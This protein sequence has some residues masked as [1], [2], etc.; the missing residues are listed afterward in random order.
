[1]KCSQIR[2]ILDFATDGELGL[3]TTLRVK[4]HLARCAACR[5]E[6][7]QV[8]AARR[9]LASAATAEPPPTLRET[10]L[11]AAR[12][13]PSHRPIPRPG[14][15]P[16]RAMAAA[17]AVL[18]VVA[19][20]MAAGIWSITRPHQIA[21]TPPAPGPAVVAPTSPAAAPQVPAAPQ[22]ADKGVQI[23]SLPAGHRA[24][25]SA[26]GI[27][28]RPESGSKSGPPPVS[29]PRGGGGGLD[30]ESSSASLSWRE[31]LDAL[32]LSEI[33]K[34]HNE[35]SELS[36]RI[37]SAKP[38]KAASVEEEPTTSTHIDEAAA[39]NDMA[40][41]EAANL[42]R[43]LSAREAAWRTRSGWARRSQEIRVP[44]LKSKF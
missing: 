30:S 27:I 35:I 31:T 41:E 25:G 14:R 36:R 26:S 39:A 20:G 2:S 28:R 44:V 42:D 22:D 19:V 8:Q 21:A 29:G 38:D 17:A 37:S 23:A 40:K 1:V 12:G 5:R 4:S 6:L 18:A 15:A 24:A 10:I 34:E 16:A 7:A 11:A 43:L 32:A 3:L 13:E 9:L 33:A